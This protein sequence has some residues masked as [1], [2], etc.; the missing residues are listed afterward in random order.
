MGELNTFFY[1]ISGILNLYIASTVVQDKDFPKKRKISIFIYIFAIV[2]LF[3]RSMQQYI[4]ILGLLGTGFLL[5]Y[6]MSEKLSNIISF[7]IGYLVFVCL[8]YLFANV[9]YFVFGTILEEIQEKH[10]MVF[11]A[12]FVPALFGVEKMLQ[13]LLHTKFQIKKNFATSRFALGILGN[14]SVSVVI[15]A[16]LIITGEQVGYPPQIITINGILI[17]SQFCLSSAMLVGIMRTEKREHEMRLQLA[18]YET[19]SA[20]THEIEQLYEN[21]RSFKHDYIDLLSSMKLYIDEGNQEKLSRYFYD[22]IL[23]M[24]SEV[25]GHDRQLG[26]LAYVKNDKIKSLLFSKILLASEHHIHVEVEV[27]EKISDFPMKEMELLR[28]LGIF[29]NNAIEA[30]EESAEKE[31]KLAVFPKDQGLVILIQNSTKP[32]LKPLDKLCERGFSSKEQH[33]G[34]GLDTAVKIL[35]TYKNVFWNF[36]YEKPYFFTELILYHEGK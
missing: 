18:Q 19:L 30:A 26:K 22:S 8:D 34:L 32:L 23:P 28:V 7:L 24:G 11:T 2:F 17:F 3:E 33:S 27:R 10:M 25:M 31:L 4:L 1:Y 36:S 35:N 5:V 13:W 14:L 6:K 20:Y 16:I 9:G 29:L 12:V 15:F 21:M